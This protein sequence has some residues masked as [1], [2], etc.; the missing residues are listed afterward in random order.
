MMAVVG[1]IF[2]VNRVEAR[3]SYHDVPSEEP[4][5]VRELMLKSWPQR[6]WGARLYHAF[7]PLDRVDPILF[8]SLAPAAQKG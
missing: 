3:R 1:D 7:K 8:E 6:R 2:I 4:Q 5:L